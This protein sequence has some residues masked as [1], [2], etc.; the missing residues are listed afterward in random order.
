VG[1]KQEKR[2]SRLKRELKA[3]QAADIVHDKLEDRLA[4]SYRDGYGKAL[5]VAKEC[6]TIAEVRKLAVPST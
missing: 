1:K 6:R 3:A 4:E 5:A 2:I